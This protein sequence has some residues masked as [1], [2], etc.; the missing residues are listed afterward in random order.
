MLQLTYDSAFAKTVYSVPA[1]TV[2]ELLGGHGSEAR[3]VRVEYS[4][5]DVYKTLAK[6]LQIMDDFKV[7]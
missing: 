3:A 4:N 5:K 7:R 2:E 1:V 6:H